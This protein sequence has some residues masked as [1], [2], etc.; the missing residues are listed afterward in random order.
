MGTIIG[1]QGSRI[2]SLQ[3]EYGVKITASKDFLYDSTERLVEVQGTPDQIEQVLGVLSRCLLEDWHNGTGTSFYVPT[4]RTNPR[5]HGNNNTN[6][7]NN[8][9]NNSNNNNNS[10]NGGATSSGAGS[11]TA[12]TANGSKFKNAI[13][14]KI[15]YPSDMVGCLIGKEGSRIQE[16]R[17]VT[18]TQIVIDSKDDENDER[19]F[20]LVGA[21]KNVERAIGYLNHNLEKER[22]RRERLANE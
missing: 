12:N 9:N 6:N 20:E 8:T 18:G 11:A 14:K 10:I 22:E 16:I 1:K 7:S 13:T 3:S 19:L 5:Y 21:P 2:K 15:K 17:K 4:P